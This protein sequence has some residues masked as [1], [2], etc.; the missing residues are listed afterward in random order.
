M[1]FECRHIMH[2]GARCHSPA[3]RGKDYCYYHFRLHKLPKTAKPAGTEDVLKLP[4]I[5]DRS[6]ILAALSQI[7]DA[8]STGKLESKQAGNFLYALQIATQNVERK[9]DIL[10]FI[11]VQHVS[12]THD[13][14]ELAPKL[15]V[16]ES[17]DTC[18]ACPY[19][20][21]CRDYEPDEEENVD[22]FD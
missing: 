17:F 8:L 22:R 1:Y 5:E 19:Q 3:L 7:L 14:E 18:S 2:N 21:T 20:E 9:H 13:G 11:A 6:S 16:C 12:L 15:A 4:F 10:P